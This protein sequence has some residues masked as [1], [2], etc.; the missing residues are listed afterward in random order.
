MSASEASLGTLEDEREVTRLV[1]L[2]NDCL[3]SG[4]FGRLGAEVFASDVVVDYNSIT[5]K[6]SDAVIS[7]VAES[8]AQFKTWAHLV[9]NVLLKSCDGDTAEVTAAQTVWIWVNEAN[10]QRLDNWTDF[11]QLFFTW[12]RIERRPEGWRIVEHRTRMRGLP[13]SLTLGP[14]AA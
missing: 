3:D 14:M 12:D 9:S 5:L 6:G 8:M 4:E 13:S 11:V 7:H 1:V 10:P 2:Y